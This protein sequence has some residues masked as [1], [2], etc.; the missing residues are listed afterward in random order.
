MNPKFLH[1]FILVGISAFFFLFNSCKNNEEEKPTIP[2]NILKEE[3]F[4]KLLTSFALAESA[5]NMNIKS[6]P[7]YKMDTVYAFNPLIEHGVRKSQYD[8]TLDFYIKHPLL[9]KKVY[10]NVLA[11]LT[12]LQTKRDSLNNKKK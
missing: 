5:S 8:S 4:T 10:E 11:E 2:E 6:V 9:Y 1:F 3:A 7:G 12:D